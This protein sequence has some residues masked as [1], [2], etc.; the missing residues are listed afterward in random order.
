[1]YNKVA[2]IFYVIGILPVSKST[3]D[4]NLKLK[5]IPKGVE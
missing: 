2:L 4:Q 3:T 5:W 1:M